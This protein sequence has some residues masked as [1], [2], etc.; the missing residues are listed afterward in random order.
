VS[1]W[2]LLTPIA[3]ALLLVGAILMPVG[4]VLAL[5][6][7]VGLM[8][9]VIAS[10]H[11]A[12]VVAHRVGEPFGTLVLSLAITIIEVALILSMML[13]NPTATAT[14]PRDTVFATVMIICNGVV[15]LCLLVGGIRHREQS[16]HLEGANTGLATLIALSSLA[17][18][19]PAFTTTVPGPT[20]SRAQLA[21][22]SIAS[23]VLWATFVFVQTVRHRD[24]FLSAADPDAAHVQAGPPSDRLAAASFGLLLVALIA[25][26][27]LA[28]VLSPKIEMAMAAAGA[29]KS[30]IGIVIALLVLLPETWAAAR[31]AAA[32][33]LQTSF[34]LAFG[35][36]L[37]SIG[38]TIPAVAVASVFVN[39][40]LAL[41]LDSKELVLLVLSFVVASITLVSGRTHV[42]PGVVHLV[43]F[44]AFVFFALIP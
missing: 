2:A 44:A 28:K 21:F 43:I 42:M 16:F 35:S 40:P 37:A 20:Y 19:L 27:G 11:H 13:A 30:A 14:L 15:G 33:Q 32:N 12:E 38:L 41:G 36:A 34:N 10:V 29:P 9:S 24:Y 23:I 3:S 7:L 25:V 22:A 6:C 4:A 1:R 39:V 18:V 26:V 5:V 17:L 31:A 8:G